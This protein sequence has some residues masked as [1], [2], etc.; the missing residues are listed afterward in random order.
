M[1]ASGF[2]ELLPDL[3]WEAAFEIGEVLPWSV[4]FY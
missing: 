1:C 4:S 2:G 3:G